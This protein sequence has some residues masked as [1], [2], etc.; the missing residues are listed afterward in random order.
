MRM[1]GFLVVLPALFLL[2]GPAAALTLV[3]A[4]EAALP[5][6]KPLPL[7]P[8]ANTARGITRGP[9]IELQSPPGQG[10]PVRSPFPLRID[11]V[12][13]GGAHINPASVKVIYLR[14]GNIDLTGRLKSEISAT[15]INVP[16]AETPPGEHA[17]RIEVEDDEGRG[18]ATDVVI[19]VSGG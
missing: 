11:F 17:F 15:G 14:Q 7:L 9:E 19:R 16:D 3:T 8:P 2:A 5:T 6:A 10:K 18:S 12:A 13:H 1:L 4:D